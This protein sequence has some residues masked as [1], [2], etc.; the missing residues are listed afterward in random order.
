V[1][2]ALQSYRGSVLLVTHDPGAVR[3]LAPQ[4]VILLPDGLQDFWDASFEDLVT[5]T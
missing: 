2:G 1:L 4:R 3:A 5:L